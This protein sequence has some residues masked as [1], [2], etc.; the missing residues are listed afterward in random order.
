MRGA[1]QAL[2]SHN[3]LRKAKAGSVM[4]ASGIACLKV[5]PISLPLF[6]TTLAS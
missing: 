1:G 6:Q 5:T 3:C 2:V 4:P